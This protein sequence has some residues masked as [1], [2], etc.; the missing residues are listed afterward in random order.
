MFDW[1]EFLQLAENLM[2]DPS[3]EAALRSAMSRA[4]YA[5]F[6]AGRDYLI[7]AEIPINRGRNAH[8]QVQNELEKKSGKIGYDLERLHDWR[9]RAD[10]DTPTIPDVAGQAVLAVNLARQTIEAIK[11]IS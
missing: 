2:D 6:H 7:R 5:T 3:N 8:V 11:M 4:Y 10:Y 9:K 1:E